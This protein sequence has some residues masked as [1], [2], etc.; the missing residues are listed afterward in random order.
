MNFTGLPDYLKDFLIYIEV[1]QGKSKA[2]ANEYLLDLRTFLR[3]IKCKTV[4]KSFDNFDKVLIDDISI[5][6]IK[7][8]DSENHGLF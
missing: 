1:I 5:D 6:L 4:L 2:T 8:I 7:Q 3:Y